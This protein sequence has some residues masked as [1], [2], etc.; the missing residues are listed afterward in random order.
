MTSQRLN[1]NLPEAMYQYDVFLD[2]SV[3]DRAVVGV[4]GCV[5]HPV[6]P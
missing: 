4:A 6:P 2:E 1:A 3:M 5:N